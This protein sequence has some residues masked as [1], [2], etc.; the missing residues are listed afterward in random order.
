MLSER[1][2]KLLTAYIDGELDA[3]RREAVLSHVQKSPEAREVLRQLQEDANRLRQLPILRPPQDLSQKIAQ[4]LAEPVVLPMRVTVP[5]VASPFPRGYGLA[6]A[7]AVLLAMGVGAWYYLTAVRDVNQP[8]A[9]AQQVDG[10]DLTVKTDGLRESSKVAAE[11]KPSVEPATTSPVAEKKPAPA[12]A[13]WDLVRPADDKLAKSRDVTPPSKRDEGTL[14]SPDRKE[15]HFA[16]IPYRVAVFMP[17]RE[18]TQRNRQEEL[19]D[20][21]RRASAQHLDLYCRQTA[22]ALD[23][24]QGAFKAQSIQF[25][26]TPD[27]ENAH[28]LGLKTDYLLYGENVTPDDVVAVL[29]QVAIDERKAE[30]GRRGPK[31]PGQFQNVLVDGISPDD[32]KLLARVLKVDLSKPD[33]VQGKTP[34]GI[35]PLKPLA[36]RTADEVVRSLKGQGTPRPEPGRS[37]S[38]APERLLVVSTCNPIHPD[39]KAAQVQRF[40]TSRKD[41]LPG[42]M[43]VLIVLRGSSK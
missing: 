14:T 39:P 12:P 32:Y 36:T 1:L 28:K 30:A 27:A 43:Q 37:M 18:L 13:P 6:T 33:G 10:N 23:R 40:L 22:T 15:D 42:M 11:S 25:V 31:Q 34:P 29:R 16:P 26:M 7:A 5:Q 8:T 4:R 3:R 9:Q 24:L 21:L 20:K 19:A 35:D 2:T 17:A 38:K 41:R